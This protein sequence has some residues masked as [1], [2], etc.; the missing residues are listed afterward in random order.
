MQHAINAS[1][2]RNYNIESVEA[3]D[4]FTHPVLGKQKDICNVIASAIKRISQYTNRCESEEKS[5]QITVE[6]SMAYDHAIEHSVKLY[7]ILFDDMDICSTDY[8]YIKNGCPHALIIT[9]SADYTYAEC[10]KC[11]FKGYLLTRNTIK[12]GLI[13]CAE[14]DIIN[15]GLYYDKDGYIKMLKC[16]RIIEVYSNG[17]FVGGQEYDLNKGKGNKRIANS[18][19][20]WNFLD[21]RKSQKV[22]E[23]CAK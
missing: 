8:F 14:N 1:S 22:A 21:L 4:V 3:K 2:L 7:K 23:I 5:R 10:E 12:L 6:L 9:G 19:G 17:L 15:I 13:E 16:S 20:K 11:F 18:Y